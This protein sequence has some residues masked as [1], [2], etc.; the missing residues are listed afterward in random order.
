MIS[1]LASRLSAAP[2]CTRSS[3]GSDS[4]ASPCIS[5]STSNGGCSERIRASAWRI[6]R[7][8]GASPLPK[9]E[10]EISAT[11]GVMPKRRTSSAASTVISASW[12]GLGSTLT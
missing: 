1:T 11:C 12:A 9:L 4:A 3:V 2:G 10:C 6:L 7:A 5:P 8:L